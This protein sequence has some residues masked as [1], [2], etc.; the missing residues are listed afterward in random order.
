MKSCRKIRRKVVFTEVE[1]ALPGKT[2]W[3][4]RLECGHTKTVGGN[5]DQWG[6]PKTTRCKECEKAQ[7]AG[8]E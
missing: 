5:Y 2:Y 7:A 6:P 1:T 4:A 3:F 8:G